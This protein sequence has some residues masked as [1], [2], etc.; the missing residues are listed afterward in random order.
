MKSEL[1]AMR[2]FR[3]VTTLLIIGLVVSAA[4]HLVL[5]MS[6]SAEYRRW[7]YIQIALHSL[8]V[9]VLWYVRRFNPFA[10]AALVLLGALGVYINGEYLN[11]G[12]GAVLWI[13]PLIF[14]TAYLT[15]AFVAK[16]AFTQH[17]RRNDV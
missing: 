15:I 4:L 10:L 17:L 14:F 7:V 1:R 16:S 12:N 5:L 3:V 8:C 13:L 2:L 11:Y 6:D 9:W